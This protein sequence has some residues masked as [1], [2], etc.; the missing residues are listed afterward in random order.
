MFLGF[1]DDFCKDDKVDGFPI[2]GKVKDVQMLKDKNIFTHVILGIGYKHSLYKKDLFINLKEKKILFASIIS[3]GTYI[4]KSVKIGEGSFIL[5]GV[6]LDK[7][8]V[9]GDNNVIN[10]GVV[11]AHDSEVCNHCF[12][13]PRVTLAGFI[14]IEDMCFLGIGTIVIDNITLC[15]STKTG[16]GAVITKSTFEKGLYLG[17]P[18]KI[19]K[20]ID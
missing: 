16:G 14:K 17:I 10:T 2:L 11:I 20:R 13:G 1:V 9:V 4:D 3:K 12:L 15:E 5:P 18:A 7:D 19:K 6:T 8:V